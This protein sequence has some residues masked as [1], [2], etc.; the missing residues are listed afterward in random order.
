MVRAAKGRGRRL[1]LRAGRGW[2]RSGSLV[3]ADAA[4]VVVVVVV[5]VVAELVAVGVEGGTSGS[6]VGWRPDV[7]AR[8]WWSVS[9]LWARS[10]CS[11]DSYLVGLALYSFVEVIGTM[12]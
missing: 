8:T 10:R 1:R 5:V 3:V 6:P 4:V 7:A 9:L 12:S 11:M 2:N